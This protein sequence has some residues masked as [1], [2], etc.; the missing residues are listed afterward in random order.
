MRIYKTVAGVALLGILLVVSGC[1][2]TST[3]TADETQP[4]IAESVLL[5]NSVCPMMGGKAK[6]TVTVQWNEKTIGFC[7]PDCIPAWEELSDEQRTSKLAEAAAAVE[8]DSNEADE[9]DS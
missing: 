9:N 8:S 7:C 6:D 2:D 5:A 3:P 4:P 1:A